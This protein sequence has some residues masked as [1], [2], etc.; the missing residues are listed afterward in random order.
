MSRT[1]DR[2]A[3]STRGLN[4][5]NCIPSSMIQRDDHADLIRR[6]NE[7]YRGDYNMIIFRLGEHLQITQ[8]EACKMVFAVLGVPKAGA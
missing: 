5:A 4:K 7:H 3:G 6:L 2:A 8:N 1:Y